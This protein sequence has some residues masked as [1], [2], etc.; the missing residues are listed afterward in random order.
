MSKFN[1]HYKFVIVSYLAM[2]LMLL[3]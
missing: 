1:V 3:E 2:Q